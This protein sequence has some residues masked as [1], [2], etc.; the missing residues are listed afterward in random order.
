MEERVLP[1][2]RGRFQSR[3]ALGISATS[4]IGERVRPRDAVVQSEERL[5][6]SSPVSPPR[7]D[8]LVEYDRRMLL[9]L[10]LIGVICEGCALQGAPVQPDSTV[11]IA[12]V[13]RGQFSE[14]T[15]SREAFVRDPAGWEALWG[16]HAP[17]QPIPTVEFSNRSVAAVFLGSRP[18]GGF[19]IEIT[20][21]HRE[22][23]TLVVEYTERAPMPGAIVTQV[24]TAPFHIATLPRHDGA[25]RFEK[26]AS[27]TGSPG[28]P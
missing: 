5:W 24:I 3:D 20:G 15:E 27:N 1:G 4:E 18:T 21:A 13:A 25:V 17:G 7:S 22:G 19:S 6:L 9:W 2:F 28:R 23:A 12:P 16:M 11:H 14:I 8:P 26:R 10:V